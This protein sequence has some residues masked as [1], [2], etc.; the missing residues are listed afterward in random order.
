MNVI[1]L[2]LLSIPLYLGIVL[3]LVHLTLDLTRW[4]NVQMTSPHTCNF[5]R[6][7]IMTSTRSLLGWTT[8]S[9][10]SNSFKICHVYPTDCLWSSLMM[11]ITSSW[12]KLRTRYWPLAW[13]GSQSPRS[14]TA[15]LGPPNGHYLLQK[16]PGKSPNYGHKRDFHNSLTAGDLNHTPRKCN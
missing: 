7:E 10:T 9:N 13:S 16:T 11:C 12:R 5:H 15:R 14:P 3:Y 4:S 8:H 6:G 1:Y 2:P